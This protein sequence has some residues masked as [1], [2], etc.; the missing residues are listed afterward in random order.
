MEDSYQE[1]NAIMDQLQ[2]FLDDWKY[3]KPDLDLMPLA[4]LGRIA[5]LMALFETVRDQ[6]LLPFDLKY[7]EFDVLA[8]LRRQGEPYTLSPT[9]LYRSLLLS[10]GAISKR[11]DKLESAGLISRLPDPADRR[12]WQI[13]LTAQGLLRVEEALQAHTRAQQAMLA[14]IPAADQQQIAALLGNWLQ[15][16]EQ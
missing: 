3:S 1:G 6:A 9:V 7:G 12:A 5:R 15:Q 2:Q 16:L 10:S 4:V 14:R 11:L 8:T 13:S